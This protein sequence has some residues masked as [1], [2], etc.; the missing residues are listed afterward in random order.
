MPHERC[1]L[2]CAG[3]HAPSPACAGRGD[4]VA[5]SNGMLDL[6]HTILIRENSFVAAKPPFWSSLYGRVRLRLRLLRLSRR[7]SARHFRLA[8]RRY[9]CGRHD[10]ARA[11]MP[12]SI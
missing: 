11:R 12:G 10:L 3:S 1:E 9:G 4:D 6:S 2:T 5:F 7:Q 8:C